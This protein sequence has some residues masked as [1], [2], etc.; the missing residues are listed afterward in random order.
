MPVG[1]IGIA[2]CTLGLG[3]VSMAAPSFRSPLKKA[4]KAVETDA[5]NEKKPYQWMLP[6]VIQAGLVQREGSVFFGDSYAK[7]K[8]RQFEMKQEQASIG[9]TDSVQLLYGE[10]YVLAKGRSSSSR[11]D[12]ADSY[13]GARVVVKRPTATDSS[14]LSLQFGAVR[15]DTGSARS[16]GSS[17]TFAGTHNNIFSVNY[18]DKVKNQY[19]VQ[20]TDITAPGGEFAHVYNVGYGREY[21][22]SEFVLARLQGSII[23]ESFQAIGTSSNYEMR[24]V[25][26]G[27]LAVNPTPWLSLE[28][29]ITAFPMGTP[30]GGGEY[31]G[32][33]GFDL[34]SPGGI[35]DQL[36]SEFVAFGSARILIHGKF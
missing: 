2:L 24:P 19:Q 12:V 15:P 23:T 3:A 21:E 18:L 20:Y 31:T 25:L 35:V 27:C 34:Y 1:A 9:V 16:G 22:L 6:S 14:A 8:G 5:D 7:F 29:D 11:F 28:A 13:Y 36:R 30:L 17:A 33:S 26:Y 4:V 32:F 10:Q